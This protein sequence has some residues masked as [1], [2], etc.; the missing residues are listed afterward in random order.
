MLLLSVCRDRDWLLY[1]CL[2]ELKLEAALQMNKNNKSFQLLWSYT[3]GNKAL[4]E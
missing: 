1:C 3:S 2:Q 4:Q